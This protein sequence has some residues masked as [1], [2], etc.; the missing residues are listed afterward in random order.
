MSDWT[1][2]G[3]LCKYN[4]MVHESWS[5]PGAANWSSLSRGVDKIN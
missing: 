1:E 3:N 2:N 5:M 4:V